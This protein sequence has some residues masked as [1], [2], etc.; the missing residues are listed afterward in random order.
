M[1]KIDWY[2]G[3]CDVAFRAHE[4]R[5]PACNKP[6]RAINKFELTKPADKDE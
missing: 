4:G 6:I 1:G 2:C 3:Y 5:C